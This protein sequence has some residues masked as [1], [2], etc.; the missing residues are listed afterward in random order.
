MSESQVVRFNARR[1]GLQRVRTG[2]AT[3]KY[4]HRL[5]G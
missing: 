2:C 4:V 5:I 3:C 1:Q